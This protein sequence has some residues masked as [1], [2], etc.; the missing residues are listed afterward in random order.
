MSQNL[1]APKTLQNWSQI[2]ILSLFQR[3]GGIGQDDRV[4]KK[5]LYAYIFPNFMVNRYGPWL[6][7]NLVIPTSMFVQG[8]LKYVRGPG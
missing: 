3:V 1:Y 7:T 2:F 8:R 5:A 4:G 6:D